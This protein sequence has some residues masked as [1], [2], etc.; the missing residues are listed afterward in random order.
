MEL[1]SKDNNLVSD[2]G[3]SQ[4]EKQ[5]VR[6]M[7]VTMARVRVAQSLAGKLGAR[8]CRALEVTGFQPE[9]AIAGHLVWWGMIRCYFIML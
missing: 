4:A 6:K 5:C 2:E 1:Q 9:T 7:G 8:S 3:I